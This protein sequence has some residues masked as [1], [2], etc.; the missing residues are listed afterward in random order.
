MDRLLI[1][2]TNANVIISARNAV[3]KT[4]QCVKV[5]CLC[6]I[7]VISACSF[8]HLQHPQMVL[9]TSDYRFNCIFFKLYFYKSR[10]I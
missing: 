6:P 10:P 4:M 9:K 5:K 3:Y 8:F 2:L 1:A 7:M